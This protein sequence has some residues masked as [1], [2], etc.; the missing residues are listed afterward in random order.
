MLKRPGDALRDKVAGILGCI[1]SQV[2]IEWSLTATTAD[3]YYVDDTN[4]L[5][6][7]RVAIECKD[8]EAGLSSSDLAKIHSL[9]YPSIINKE[10]DEI[11]VIGE[12]DL[13]QNPSETAKNLPSLKYISYEKFVFSIMNFSYVMQENISVYKNHDSYKNFIESRVVGTDEL[14]V[15]VAQD[16]LKSDEN[17]L[18]T[19]GGYGIGKTSFSIYFCSKMTE[20]FRSGKFARIPIRLTLGDLYTKQD[21]KGVIC[22]TLAGSESGAA[23]K[24]F[25]YPLF[26]DM[27]RQGYFLLIL[28]GFDEMRHA[29]TL[30]DF[31]FTFEDMADLFEGDAKAIIL[32]RPDSFF[33]DEEEEEIIDSVI[34]V[35]IGDAKCKKIEIDR[36]NYDQINKYL[37]KY[38]DVSGN[39]N[40]LEYKNY[41]EVALE[42]E[43]D[44]LSRP[45]QLKMFTAVM[46]RLISNTKHFSRY[47]LYFNFIYRFVSRE[48]SKPSRVIGDSPSRRIGYDD[49]RTVF[50]QRLAWWLLTEKKENRFRPSEIPLEIVPSSLRQKYGSDGGLREI[51]LG[52]V[53]EQCGGQDRG[54]IRAKGQR[55]Y[56]FPHKSYVEFLVAEYFCREKFSGEMYN[57]FFRYAN[58]EIISFLGDAP[59]EA[60][61]NVRQGIESARG[62]IASEILDIAVRDPEIEKEEN[63]LAEADTSEGRL[64]LYYGY[65]RN[66]NYDKSLIDRFLILA[67][68]KAKAT[69]RLSAV[70]AMIGDYLGKYGSKELCLTVINTALNKI[71]K[72]KLA[73][74]LSTNGAT[75]YNF[76]SEA[77][78]MIFANRC[79]KLRD[80][81]IVLDIAELKIFA[82]QACKKGLYISG[83]DSIPE[84]EFRYYDF[85]F[86]EISGISE[87]SRQIISDNYQNNNQRFRLNIHG[88]AQDSMGA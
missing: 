20:E 78:H 68:N 22:S 24:N 62:V 67:L 85:S 48:N 40:Y 12:R 57:S 47:D 50:M 70:Y 51:I 63:R 77:V 31:K 14:L 59:A 39:S 88:N 71:G 53:V 26:L 11:L 35:V 16:W 27:N 69:S 23:V 36:L 34:S 64:Y 10:I 21:L 87:E 13:S 6:P 55:Q 82:R 17:V 56:Y 79:L 38:I 29:M 4:Q 25:S 41:K 5:F 73:D 80:G 44:V 76:D 58:N 32:G 49:E 81:K 65:I 9:Y 2:E 30:D 8:W 86:K 7:R 1:S 83:F 46:S 75:V 18:L 61:S 42:N 15:S 19:F 84:A 33:S 72:F 28:D 45:V 37:D 66:K 52:S 74:M 54:V 60:V 43:S 3:V